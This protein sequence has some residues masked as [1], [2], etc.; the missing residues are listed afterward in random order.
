MLFQ[1][2][3]TARGGSTF[4]YTRGSKFLFNTCG[5]AG[6]SELWRPKSSSLLQSTVVFP[7][8]S[9][10]KLAGTWRSSKQLQDSYSCLKLFSLTSVLENDNIFSLIL[11][12]IYSIFTDPCQ[13]K[14]NDQRVASVFRN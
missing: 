5:A 11:F 9:K 13:T 10:T 14:H 4:F 1:I 8:L 7:A 12:K 2:S 6:S 3:M